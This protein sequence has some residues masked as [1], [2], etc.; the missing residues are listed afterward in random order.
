[1][2]AGLPGMK[3]VPKI[4]ICTTE[5]NCEQRAVY[6][7]YIMKSKSE[8]FLYYVACDDFNWL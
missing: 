5:T 2:K 6:K 8:E 4:Q 1:M 7:L 3:G